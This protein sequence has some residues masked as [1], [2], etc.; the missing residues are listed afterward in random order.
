MTEDASY[1]RLFQC[2]ICGKMFDTKDIQQG[3][4]RKCRRESQLLYN[5]D[6]LDEQLAKEISLTL[7]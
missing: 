1:F 2:S 3:H 7:R 4:E 5:D 6:T